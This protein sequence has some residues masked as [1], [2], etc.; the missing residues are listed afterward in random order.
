[1]MKKTMTM[2]LTAAMILSMSVTAFA[3]EAKYSV[4]VDDDLLTVNNGETKATYQLEDSKLSL[5]K[6]NDGGIALSFRTEDEGG[7]KVTLGEQKDVS[8]SGDIDY[9]NISQTLDKDYTIQLDEDADIK[10][11]YSDGNAQIKV[12]G[13]ISRAYLS[14]SGA[15]LTANSGS[16]VEVV[17]AKNKNSV[18]GLLSHRVKS[19]VEPPKIESV[20]SNYDYDRYYYYDGRYY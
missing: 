17:Y 13:E 8:I 16:D 5:S 6:S 15:K 14:S 9:L 4:S 18:K 11:L 12:D 20:S 10:E 3:A 1:M 2:L 7:K 19:Y